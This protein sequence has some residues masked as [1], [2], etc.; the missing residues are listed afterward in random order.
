MLHPFFQL[1][2]WLPFALDWMPLNTPRP[3]WKLAES[4]FEVKKAATVALM[5]S[6]RYVTDHRARHWSTVNRE[7]HCQL[8]LAA[9]YPPTAG[10]LEHLL[11]R[12][13]ALAETRAN[14]VSMWSAYLVDK[15][16]LLPIIVHHTLGPVDKVEHLHVQ[17]LLDPAS[18]PMVI[19]AVQ[20]S[21]LAV[22]SHLLY[23]T[24]TW[25]YSHHLK[26]YRLL[27]LLNII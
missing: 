20:E 25:C 11:L 2:P 24:R 21:G 22:L 4:P 13:S 19:S 18:C 26:R 17:L 9:G 3:L 16:Y 5:I 7:G 10:T 1:W 15:S 23:M 14:A 6:G 8:C 27:K 12:C